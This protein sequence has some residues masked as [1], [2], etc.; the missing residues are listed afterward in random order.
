MRIGVVV[1][2]IGQGNLAEGEGHPRNIGL[3]TDLK[4]AIRNIFLLAAKSKDVAQKQ[5]RGI[6]LGKIKAGLLRFII[7]KCRKA[8]R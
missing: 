2:K 7:R 5:A 1:E 6:V 3:S 4:G 8:M